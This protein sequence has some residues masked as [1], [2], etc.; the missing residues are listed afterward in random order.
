MGNT[1][2]PLCL[3]FSPSP[4]AYSGTRLHRTGTIPCRCL[5][6][7]VGISSLQMPSAWHAWLAFTCA[8]VDTNATLYSVG[9]EAAGFPGP[10]YEGKTLAIRGHMRE[11]IVVSLVSS[12]TLFGI[13]SRGNSGATGDKRC[14]RT[15]ER[16]QYESS[17]CRKG[18]SQ[19]LIN[20]R[21]KISSTWQT[22]SFQ[23]KKRD[24][25]E[26]RSVLRDV[27]GGAIAS[28]PEEAVALGKR[29]QHGL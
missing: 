2:D 15:V 23:R 18:P 4:H 7:G 22:G 28:R 1:I 6:Q 29:H 8:E 12:P 16:L 17:D 14:L 21:A 13:T 24:R 25:P 5:N 3:P 26:T 11:R 19:P 27:R 20:R 10:L 9:P